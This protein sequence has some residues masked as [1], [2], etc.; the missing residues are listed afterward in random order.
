MSV[1]EVARAVRDLVERANAGRLKQQELEGGCLSL[2][3]LGMY[4]TEE[5]SAIINPPQAAILSVGAIRE[6]PVVRK[7]KL[8][9]GRV[10]HFVLSVDHRSVDGAVAAD[11]MRSFLAVLESPL[12]ILA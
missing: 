10:L 5:F 7:G 8:K 2:S 1:T 4:G 6:E 3:N 12:Q 9:V 11:W